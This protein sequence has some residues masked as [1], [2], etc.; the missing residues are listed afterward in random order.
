[1][2]Q[3]TFSGEA[4]PH[5]SSCTADGQ[6]LVEQN[7][8]R[9]IPVG[10]ALV[11]CDLTGMVPNVLHEVVVR[12]DSSVVFEAS[13][14]TTVGDVLPSAGDTSPVL[15]ALGAIFLSLVVLLGYGRAMDV[16]AGR[17]HGRSAHFY[18]APAMFALAIL[19]FY[20]VLYGIWLAFTDADATRLGDQPSSACRI[21]L[22]S[23]RLRASFV[24][25]CLRWYGRW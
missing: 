8:E 13:L 17:L 22:R 19:T 2:V 21:S 18:I 3:S 10:A 9:I 11:E 14:S 12:G 23:S 4:L 6:E 16:R 25:P 24:S 5:Y 15:F 20:P 7:G 1:M